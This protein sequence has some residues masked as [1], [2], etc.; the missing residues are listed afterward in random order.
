MICIFPHFAFVDSGTSKGAPTPPFD[1]VIHIARTHASQVV[2]C[3]MW[4]TLHAT[5]RTP[6]GASCFVYPMSA[7]LVKTQ[8]VPSRHCRDARVCGNTTTAMHGTCTPPPLYGN[9]NP[10]YNTPTIMTA[11]SGH[12]ASTI[13]RVSHRAT[14]GHQN[15]RIALLKRPRYRT[16]Q[17]KGRGQADASPRY[18]Y[19]GRSL[20]FS[21]TFC[22]SGTIYAC[23]APIDRITCMSYN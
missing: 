22:M 21:S 13:L 5:R 16:E 12:T 11:G 15:T 8:S 14:V 7:L 23:F 17:D 3:R 4:L 1:T 10:H 19:F 6:N 20:Q 2:L 18:R 9:V